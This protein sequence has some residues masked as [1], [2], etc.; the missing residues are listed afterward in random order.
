MK[1]KDLIQVIN[2]STKIE[3]FEFGVSKFYEIDSI[4]QEL[5]EKEIQG[6][7]ESVYHNCILAITLKK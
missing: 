3:I 5:Y 6:I 1:I 7:S 4:P 2:Y